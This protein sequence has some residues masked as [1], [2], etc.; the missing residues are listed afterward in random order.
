MVTVEERLWRVYAWMSSLVIVSLVLFSTLQW[1][2][3]ERQVSGCQSASGLLTPTTQPASSAAPD[4]SGE[5]LPTPIPTKLNALPQGTWSTRAGFG[6]STGADAA[7]WAGLLGAGWYLNWGVV[8]QPRTS[9]EHWQM[10]RL[11]TGC[12]VPTAQIIREVAHHYPGQVWIIGN[13]PDVMW[14]DNLTPEQYAQHYHD[15]YHLIKFADPDAEIAVAGVAQGTPLRLAYLDRVLAAYRTFYR[16]EMPVD[17]W[18]V[19]GFVLREQADSWGVGIPAGMQENADLGQL[20]EIV[21]HGRLDLFEAQL[22]AFRT[23]MAERGYRDRPLAL[24][25]FGI[26]MPA[27]YGF[28]PETVASYLQ[29]SFQWLEQASDSEIGYPADGNH[30]VQRWAWFSLADPLYPD[31]DLADLN[32]GRLTPIGAAYRANISRER[33]VE[34]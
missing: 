11:G 30:L 1:L 4:R 12:T 22:R 33:L 27:P 34:P 31:P 20:Y 25:E 23:W 26:L 7:Y 6:L 5:T 32:L 21:D 16:V 18:T 24:T 13:E 29:A 14:Q 3:E 19:H 28:P 15:L 10:V 17:V 2:G 8:A 9:L